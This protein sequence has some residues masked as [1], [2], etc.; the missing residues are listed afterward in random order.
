MTASQE[1]A[2]ER[3]DVVVEE[4]ANEELAFM[5]QDNQAEDEPKRKRY[6]RPNEVMEKK[7]CIGCG[8]MAFAVLV[9]AFLVVVASV[10]S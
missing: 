8:G 3:E 5:A 6:Y 10:F 1:P 9:G 2:S 4:E 7:G